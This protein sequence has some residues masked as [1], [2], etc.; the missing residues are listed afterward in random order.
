MKI[1]MLFLLGLFVANVFNVCA[2]TDSI[3]GRVLDRSQKPVVAATVVL[4][5][6]KDSTFLGGVLSDVTGRFR[7]PTQNVPVKIIVSC[8]GYITSVRNVLQEKNINIVLSEKEQLLNEVVVKGHVP[9]VKMTSDGFSTRIE[10]TVLAKA[11][12]ATDVLAQIPMLKKTSDGYE[13]F[14]KGSPVFY[15]NG[16]RVYDISELENLKSKNLKNVE[17][18]LNPGAKYDASA[19]AVVNITT[20]QNTDKGWGV[21]V[22]GNYVRNHYV[23]FTG[24]VN[25]NY[26]SKGFSFYDLVKYNRNNDMTWKDLNQDV[27]V[28][29][30]W[31]HNNKEKEHR[32]SRKIE[33]TMG[34]DWQLGSNSHIGAKYTIKWSLQDKML[35]NNVNNVLADGKYYDQLVTD[36]AEYGHY[37]PNRQLNIYYTGQFSGY[38]LSVDMD[39]LK[40]QSATDDDYEELSE[41]YL[42]R[43]VHSMSEV[44][45]ELF[46]Y[47]FSG[48]H[49]IGSGNLSAGVE[50]TN[51]NRHDNYTNLEEYVPTLMSQLKE[52]HTSPFMQYSA[53]TP[54]GLLTAGLRY[55]YVSFNYYSSG[56]K[57]P[58][59]SRTDRQWFPSLSWGVK[60]GGLQ[61]QL[62]YTT[63]TN[64]P[65]YRQLS[66]NVFYGD[67]YTWQTGNPLLRS[68]Y[69]H[70][71]TLQGI[72]RWLQFQLS[73]EDCRHAI[74]Y[75]AT[76]YAKNEDISIVSYKNLPS[77]KQ[78]K[79]AFVISKTFGIWNPQLTMA[80]DQQFLHVN[81]NS[82]RLCLDNPIF[83]STFNNAFKFTPTFTVFVD[84]SYQSP[85]DYRNVHLYRNVFN[86]SINLVKMI[87][88]DRMSLQLKVNDLFWTQRDGNIVYSDRMNMHLLNKYDSR[89]FSLTMSYQLNSHKHKEP[90][91]KELEKEI[92]RL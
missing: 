91:N 69:T 31:N 13:V 25:I 22:E 80:L 90:V 81:T 76:Q 17:L 15:L 9:V 27:D 4:Q 71:I 56:V 58:E 41:D 83:F 20:V 49:K 39:Y 46:S 10:N 50:Y 24:K 48:G 2:Q 84:L 92:N 32:F 52:K 30:L 40:N 28:D 66:N 12:T 62:N 87:L 88:H 63:S 38:T 18:V 75:W 37:H 65:T 77:V 59:Q 3:Y 14:G 70:N 36:G 43:S 26:H 6:Q 57:V 47:R 82:S 45:N 1:R 23:N 79:A 8:L 53:L 61:A 74:I 54:V 19:K 68:E 89:Y 29:T 21:D 16:H 51:T 7:F 72:W 64:R 42:N 60:F 55:E 86:T 34:I 33:N 67:R 35:M 78:V 5:S 73:Y 85:G 11:G 44:K